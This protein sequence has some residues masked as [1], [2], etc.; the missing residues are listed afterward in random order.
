MLQV[1]N[2][3]RLEFDALTYCWS[4]QAEISRNGCQLRVL[5]SMYTVLPY[6]AR[7]ENGRL[8][9]Q[10]IWID[11]VCIKQVNDKEILQQIDIT[12]SVQRLLADL[13]MT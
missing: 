8:I 11:A 2:L 4:L 9:T 10:H 7:C 13:V 5:H 12:S 1:F 3:A 6:L